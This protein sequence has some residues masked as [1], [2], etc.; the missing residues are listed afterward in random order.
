LQRKLDL[1]NDS[2]GNAKKVVLQPQ[3]TSPYSLMEAL[4][5][6]VSALPRDVMFPFPLSKD[7]AYLVLVCNIQIYVSNGVLAY[8]VHLPLVN[9]R[10][11]DIH[12]LISIPVPSD[13]K[14]HL[15]LDIMNSFLWIDKDK[16]ILFHDRQVLARSR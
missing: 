14:R 7:S 8:A 10:Q 11:F 5:K 12:K 2:V 9:R 16:R 1:L 15:H 4:L 6:S 3:I 13:Q